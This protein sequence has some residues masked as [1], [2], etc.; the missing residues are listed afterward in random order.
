MS[1]ATF[2]ALGNGNIA[3]LAQQ[4]IIVNG[5]GD[6]SQE[7]GSTA[8]AGN[9]S[10]PV[11]HWQ[12]SGSGPAVTAQRVANPFPSYP[13]IQ[14][15]IKINTTTAKPTLTTTDAIQLYQWIEGS[16]IAQLGLGSSLAMPFAVGFIVRPSLDLTFNVR[17]TNSAT[18]R[19]FIRRVTAP[20][21]TD[22][23]VSLTFPGETSGVW[24]KDSA[25]GAVIGFTFAAGPTYTGTRDAWLS[26]DAAGEGGTITNLGAALNNNVIVS[27]IV[28]LPGTELPPADMWPLLARYPEDEM[29]LC[30]RYF[31]R[32]SGTIGTGHA[33]TTA[34]AYITVRFQVEKRVA[35]TAYTLTGGQVYTSTGVAVAA[36]L[37]GNG[38]VSPN[39]VLIFINASSL[40]AGN[41]TELIGNFD[42]NSRT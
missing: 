18:T 26:V 3:A 17:F 22:T 11:D 36:A 32:M 39:G 4:N 23:F 8:V 21:N 20:A 30:R 19:T 35:T 34:A 14:T 40:V 25:R 37:N 33:Y 29:F 31:E 7:N 9:A 15:G 28:M 5:F 38:S 27:G 41:G 10:Y 12:I 16:R 24:P 2:N 1:R 6:V 13:G 42:V